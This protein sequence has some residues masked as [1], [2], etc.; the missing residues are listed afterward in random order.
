M[1]IGEDQATVAAW[2]RK[3]KFTLPVLLDG[4]GAVTSEYRVIATPTVFFL[5][6]NGRLLGRVIGPR[7]WGS[8]GV[9]AVLTGLL[10]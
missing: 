2:V 4:D 1:N 6:R 3:H 5:D 10:A 8:A 7:D 9:K